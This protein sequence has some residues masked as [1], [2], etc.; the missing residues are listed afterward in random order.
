MNNLNAKQNLIKITSEALKRLKSLLNESEEDVK[1][2]K[3][4]VKN[5]GCAGMAY[6]MDYVEEISDSEEIIKIEDINIIIDNSA[7]LFLLGTELDYEE[8]KLNSG[9]V[10]NNP[11]QTDACGCGES[12]TLE[13]AEIPVELQNELNS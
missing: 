9:F 4:G 1:A 8:T 12:V 5:G 3:L 6:T 13:Q 10:F 2:I 11:N 7:I